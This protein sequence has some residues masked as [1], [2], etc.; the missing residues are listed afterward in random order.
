MGVVAMSPL[1]VYTA[2]LFEYQGADAVDVTRAARVGRDER[3]P[4]L[5]FAPSWSILQPLLTR[6]RAGQITES[7]WQEYREAYLD[8]MRASYRS[9]RAQWLDLLGRKK[10][11]LLC[12]CVDAERC[13]RSILGGIVLPAL[14]AQYHGERSSAI[15]SR[16]LRW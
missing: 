9:H 3:D 4:G 1:V 11:T 15:D 14:G 16:P 10:A 6:R 12:Y 5:V 2:R 13:H 7:A 8:E